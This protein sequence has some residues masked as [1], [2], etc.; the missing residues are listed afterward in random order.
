M[1]FQE[2]VVASQIPRSRAFR[3]F[4]YSI[5]ALRNFV[6]L[7]NYSVIP[8]TE[9]IVHLRCRDRGAR[10]FIKFERKLLMQSLVGLGVSGGTPRIVEL[11]RVAVSVSYEKENVE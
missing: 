10:C 8:D 11:R 6:K 2:F 7:S 4:P 5:I 1:S 9:I 3:V